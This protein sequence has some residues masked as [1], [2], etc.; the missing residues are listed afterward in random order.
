M[1]APLGGFI[2]DTLLQSASEARKGDLVLV[3]V[4][5]FCP[6]SVQPS[7]RE[8]GGALTHRQ[9]PG[10]KH[11]RRDGRYRAASLGLRATSCSAAL[12]RASPTRR[13]ANRDKW[14]SPPV[15]VSR[16]HFIAG[17]FSDC[18]VGPRRSRLGSGLSW[19]L[20]AWATALGG[21]PSSTGD[22]ER[23]HCCFV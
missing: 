3:R 12:S 21:M 8:Y 20:G 6:Q 15:V 4:G 19:P 18:A 1:S 9:G 7:A 13:S 10:A 23:E 22:V 14:V 11:E 17:H 2:F 5:A 16:C